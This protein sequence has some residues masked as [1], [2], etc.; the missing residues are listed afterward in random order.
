MKKNITLNLIIRTLAVGAGCLIFWSWYQGRGPDQHLQMPHKEE[1]VTEDVRAD[2][3][4]I[5]NSTNKVEPKVRHVVS[6]PAGAVKVPKLPSDAPDAVK[7]FRNWAEVYF[8]AEPAA[9]ASL[10]KKGQELAG[11]HRAAIKP[12]ISSDPKLALE[13]AVPMV[14]RQD[15]PDEIEQRLERRVN[16]RGDLM[17]LATVPTDGGTAV[18]SVRHVFQPESAQVG[19]SLDAYVYGDR[20]RMRSLTNTRV[21]GIEVDNKLAVLDSPIRQ[22][23]VGERPDPAK[24]T[25]ETCPISGITTPI[26][27]NS[28]AAPAPVQANVTVVEDSKRIYVLC[29]GGHT[30]RFA[31]QLNQQET[32]EHR[33]SGL[34][35]AEGGTGGGSTPFDVPPGWTNGTKKLLY[36]RV[37]FPDNLR[38]VQSEVSVYNNLKQATDF[39][40]SNSFGRYYLTPTVAPLVVLPY[41]RSWYLASRNSGGQPNGEDPLREHAL[42]IARRMGYDADSYDLDVVEYDSNGPGSFGGQ[43]FVGARGVWLKTS[44]VGTLIHELGHN[45]GLWH[46]N[47]WETNPPNRI[48]PGNND[49]YG[50]KF[51][52]MGAS[53][54]LG[55]FV[56]VHKTIL[57]WLTPDS[58]HRAS[59]SGTYRVYQVD[60]GRAD[61][62]KRYALATNMDSERNYWF[63][64]RQRFPDIASLN[65]G[66]LVTWNAWGSGVSNRADEAFSSH[67]GSHLLDM[68]PGSGD[69]ADTRDDAGLM[70]GQTFSDADAGVHV[71]PIFKSKTVPPYVDV[72]VNR[73]VFPTNRNPTL[74]IT[75][76]TLNVPVNGT[77]LLTAVA[78]DLDSDTISYSWNFGDKT[79]STDNGRTQIKKWT[80]LGKYQ[81]LCTASDMKGGRTT[82]SMLIIVGAEQG[83]DFNYTV[84]GR[85]L[86]NSLPTPKPVEGVYI[87]SRP[88]TNGSA[89][90]GSGAFRSTYTDSDG[91]Y[92]LTELISF[93]N[94]TQATIIASKW[95][96]TYSINTTNTFTLNNDKENVDWTQIGLVTNVVVSVTD[97]TASEDNAS[98]RGTI[99]LTR[100]NSSGILNVQM[101]VNSQGTA[102]R[103]LAFDYTL[104]NETNLATYLPAQVTNANNRE[105]LKG[106]LGV[107]FASGVSTVNIRVSAL[108]DGFV[109]GTEYAVIDFPDTAYAYPGSTQP[110]TVPYHVT[111]TRKAVIAITD[112][113]GT[114]PVVSLTAD[115]Q[116]M[117]EGTTATRDSA[118]LR[119]HREGSILNP[120]TVTL[121]YG[122]PTPPTR[123]ATRV[124]DY[125]RRTLDPLTLNPLTVEIPVGKSEVMVDFDP[126][127]DL[128]AEGLEVAT[129]SLAANAGYN[130]ST[131]LNSVDLY[132]AD[133]DQPV[134]QVK[135]TVASTGEGSPSPGRL[136]VSRTAVDIRDDLVVNF[137]LGGSALSGSD[138]KRISGIAVIPAN[139]LTADIM[140]ESFQDTIDEENQ[141]V[142]LKI[143]ADPNYAIGVDSTATVTIIDNDLSQFSIQSLSSTVTEPAANPVS[144]NLFRVFRPA[145]LAVVAPGAPP[146]PPGVPIVVKYKVSPFPMSTATAS[147]LVPIATN[148]YQALYNPNAQP[149]ASTTG[150]LLFYSTDTFKDISVKLNSDSEFEDAEK[151]TIELLPGSGY[152]LGSET[153]STTVILDDDQPAIDVSYADNVGAS[154]QNFTEASTGLRFYFSRTG[155]TSASRVVD[156][157]FG[158]TAL[159]GND[160]NTGS[161]SSTQIVI[162]AGQSGA[163]LDVFLVN[164]NIA[165][166]TESISVNI[167]TPPNAGAYGSRFP[168]STIY[169][170]DN[171]AYTGAPAPELNFSA[172]TSNANERVAG[173]TPGVFVASQHTIT[174][175]LN[176]A[177][178]G[179]VRV[180]YR[181]VGGSATGRGVDYTFITPDLDLSPIVFQPGETSKTFSFTT[182]AD[183]LP[184]GDETIVFELLNPF[185]A[186]LGAVKRH[187][188]TL[189]DA[190]I[191]EVL[192][193]VVANRPNG[194][195][196][197]RGR[198][199][200][201]NGITSAWFEWGKTPTALTNRVDVSGSMTGSVFINIAQTIPVDF[202]G[203]YYYRAVAS[204][205]Y[206]PSSGIVRTIRTL[207]KPTVVTT[208][209][210]GHTATS[211]TVAGTINSNR[212]TVNYYFKWGPTD[213]F[214]QETDKLTIASG[215]NPAVV[216]ALIG[217]LTEGAPVFYQLVAESVSIPGEVFGETM[218]STA[219]PYKA[220]GDLIVNIQANQPS[221]GTPS[222]L[223]LGKPAGVFTGTAATSVNINVHDT[224]IPG[225]FFDGKTTAYELSIPTPLAPTAPWTDVIAVDS[226]TIEVWAFNPG[227]GSP[228]TLLNMGKDGAETQVAINHSNLTQTETALSHGTKNADFTAKTLPALGRWN[229][230]TYVYEGPKKTA[231]LYI[232]GV[233][234]TTVSALTLATT[235]DPITV[236][237]ARNATGVLEKYMQ[238]YINS[239]RIHGGIL[240]LPDIVTNFNLGPAGNAPAAPVVRSSGISALTA[241]SVTLNGLVATSGSASTAWIEWGTSTTYD[242]AS[243][244]IPVAVSPVPVPMTLSLANLVP[245]VEY[246]YR[247]VAS[248][249][250][251]VK[252]GKDISFI[253]AVMPASGKLW[254]DLRAG[255]FIDGAPWKNTAA[256]GDFDLIGTPTVT[257]NVLDTG[258]PGVEFDGSTDALESSVLANSDFSYGD[259]QTLEVWVLNPT[260]NN[261]AETIV[262]QG[263]VTTP[264]SRL[265]LSYGSTSGADDSTSTNSWTTPPVA[266]QWT[267]LAVVV[268]AGT[269]TLYA[270]GVQVGPTTSHPTGVNQWDDQV[271]LGATRDAAG[272]PVFGADAFS[273]YINSVKIHGGAMLASK[274]KASFDAGPTRDT[275]APILVPAVVTSAPSLTSDVHATL[276]G[277]VQAGG[278]PTTYWFE[279]GTSPSALVNKTPPTVLTNLYSL[280]TVSGPIGGLTPSVAIHY[281]LV[282]QNTVKFAQV[283]PSADLKVEGSTLTFTPSIALAGLG[284]AQTNAATLITL[285][286]ATL[287]GLATPSTAAATAWFEY[288]PTSSMTL[289]SPSVAIP[290]NAA[291]NTAPKAMTFAASGLLPHTLYSFRLVV[292]NA[293]GV[294]VGSTLTFSSFNSVPVVTAVPLK[295]ME[296]VSTPIPLKGTDADKESILFVVGVPTKGTIT[297]NSPNFIYTSNANQSG[298]D[299]F[300]YTATDGA[301]TSAPA[302][303]TVT[304]TSVND[305][306]IAINATHSGPE[307]SPITASVGASDE[308]SDPITAYFVSQEPAS[309]S[310]S[311][312]AGTGA[313]TYTP[314]VGFYGAD[315]FEFRVVAGGQTSAPGV[316]TLNVTVPSPTAL[317]TSVFTAKNVNLESK[318]LAKGPVSLTNGYAKATDPNGAQGVVTAFN[319][320]NGNF[321]FQPAL[322]YVGNASFTFTVTDG[323][324]TSAPTIVTIVVGGPEADS[325]EFS[326]VEDDQVAGTLTATDPNAI[327]L[328]YSQVT[329]A[330][331]KNGTVVVNPNGT[332]T[333]NPKAGFVGVDRFDFQATN[334]TLVSNPG[335]VTITITKRPPNW[336]WTQGTNTAKA[337]GVYGTAGAADAAN[338][339]GARSDAVSWAE[340]NG[341]LWVFGGSGFSE[342]KVAGLLND[343]W[344]RDPITREWT[345][346]SGSKGVNA[347]GI[348]GAQDLAAATN[349]PGARSGAASWLGHDGKLWMFGGN[350]F[351]AAGAKAG[352]LNDLWVFDPATSWWTWVKGS[353]NANLN[354]TYGVK[355]AS[356]S[357]NTPGARQGA[358]TWVDAEDVLWLFG[359]IGQPGTG[360]VSGSLADLWKYNPAS[361]QWTWVS[362]PGTLNINGVYGQLGEV[363]STTIPGSRSYASGWQDKDG[364][365]YLFGGNGLGA[366]GKTTGFLNDVWAY[367]PESNRWAWIKGN[368]V[369]GPASVSGLLG[370]GDP[371]NNP[372]GRAGAMTWTA[373]TEEAWVFAG[374]SKSGHMNDVWRFDMATKVWTL[375]KGSATANAG[376]VYGIKGTGA[377]SN[378]PG[379]RRG[380]IAFADV[381][382]DLWLLGGANGAA[383][384]NDLWKLDRLDS[385]HVKTLAATGETNIS[386]TLNAEFLSA[387]MN[388][389]SGFRYWP[390]GNLSQAQTTSFYQHA[391]NSS[392]MVVDESVTGLT[393]GT[394]Y[395]FQTVAKVNGMT[396]YGQTLLF[397]TTGP[398][399]GVQVNFTTVADPSTSEGDG[400]YFVEIHLSAPAPSLVT[401]PLVVS[402]P[403]PL[404]FSG[405]A[406]LNLDYKTLN[407]V[408]SFP[409]GQTSS[410]IRIPLINDF[411]NEPDELF[412]VTAS[413]PS[414]PAVLGSNDVFVLTIQDDDF[415]PF[416]ITPPTS[417]FALSGEEV[418]LSVV[419]DGSRLTYQWKRNNVVIPKAT[420]S[421]Y[422]FV[423]ALAS[424][425]IYTCVISNEL[426]FTETRADVFV[427]ETKAKST[428]ITSGSASFS[429]KAASAAGASLVYRW[430]DAL[431]TNPNGL[432]VGNGVSGT[433]SDT[434]L[435]PNVVPVNSLR[436]ICR[437]SK[438]GFPSFFRDSAVHILS[439]PD[440]API[441]TSGSL[442]DG[443]VNTFY[444]F[445]IA[446]DP[447]LRKQASK[448][449]AAGLPQGLTINS[450]TGLISGK[451]T[452]ATPAPATVTIKASSSTLNSISITRTLVI[453]ALPAG[454][455]GTFVALLERAPATNYMGG[456]VDLAITP[457]GAYTLKL[458]MNGLTGSSSGSLTPVFTP[459]NTFVGVTGSAIIKR[460]V[461]QSNLTLQF[462]VSATGVLDCVLTDPDATPSTIANET[463][464]VRQTYAATPTGSNAPNIGDY[465]LLLELQQAQQGDLEIPQ[466]NG[467]ATMKLAADGKITGAGRTADG[468]AFTLATILGP[469]ADRKIPVYA[470][471]TPVIGSLI[472]TT[473][474]DTDG[475]LSGEMTWNKGPAPAT[476]KAA[477]YPTGF[478]TISLGVIGGRYEVAPGTVVGGLVSG[479]NNARLS[480]SEGGL[481]QS[482]LDTLVF[483]IT[484]PSPTKTA[485][486]IAIPPP[487]TNKLSFSLPASPAGSFNGKVTLPNPVT[488]LTR[489]LTFQGVIVKAGAST[490]KSAGYML[491]PQLPQPGQ[492]LTTSPIYSGQIV[493]EPNP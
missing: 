118:R 344:K 424:A 277:T 318:V 224:G 263:R 167:A 421:T 18:R 293:N 73:G 189:K 131:Q 476:T 121:N 299:T 139:E 449:E 95:P 48:G 185:G 411:N 230:F 466:G 140:I 64:F 33:K 489:N 93:N 161:A 471:F 423:A 357:T 474:V 257:A 330:N 124:D 285:G 258:Y 36:L 4:A 373:G 215:T 201:N 157:I 431:D 41:P 415:A 278:S 342:G 485:Q 150:E 209:D 379:A 351:D 154:L 461:G 395:A 486:V 56:A 372:S 223:N 177:Q 191:P 328:T 443:V 246:H 173:T 279:W 346:I 307:G 390:I 92:N 250:F 350:G 235:A 27:R 376:G 228:D 401:V 312:N 200:P 240:S 204:N 262:N 265:R 488:T 402:V 163:Y 98:D 225:V 456:R 414:G 369:V 29:S 152:Q 370:V 81:V 187:T 462:T 61:A 381:S 63:E 441:I 180:N 348:Y 45:L 472:G 176:V 242:N 23:E 104:A 155:S 13:L 416:V 22:L 388:Y 481:L 317:A 212:G 313:F 123:V 340:A 375:L 417:T 473:T 47:R 387:E 403:G 174:V 366:T 114:A 216:T 275:G 145:A 127:D 386:V 57:G 354:G 460:K 435:I 349:Q 303:V 333:Y 382:G 433:Q 434:L 16:D 305:A 198:V 253:P 254:V 28:Q 341:T 410:L 397:T 194:T 432:I 282:A 463:D 14:V 195:A 260:V 359:G 455:Q 452:V 298:V 77:T 103:G 37:A 427:L 252:E 353:L 475:Y 15:L 378:T 311:L 211:V 102:T 227:Y 448:F 39:F 218:Y 197:L 111:G 445:Q 184:E 160:Y 169:I 199:L 19:Q 268:S 82:R 220:A 75:S 467:Y 419:A 71:T 84:S 409:P 323:T 464:S 301:S 454:I 343:L 85:I 413:A 26:E 458:L 425:G 202:P 325:L 20:A 206:G 276:A 393:E 142:I 196:D 273:G 146:P 290:A 347:K 487:N 179:P 480:F 383:N 450:I 430:R 65:D 321:T 219:I 226:R 337:L 280:N 446:V 94:T 135:A 295:V 12:V 309:G 6:Q 465:T 407:T 125:D 399:A 437:V 391:P 110:R 25:V 284:K 35:L 153:Q 30:D 143:A 365:L 107:S 126:F 331:A 329:T 69:F 164:D 237:A 358:T 113:D 101:L 447:D 210:A 91:Y 214:G 319:A 264:A 392:S 105:E 78:S 55:D 181:L 229:L 182:T 136:Q 53:N 134:V 241:N 21:S 203:T 436:Y 175:S 8:A 188:V 469:T 422:K 137:S 130:I 72:V 40:M 289:K 306:P 451:P 165:E 490:W 59:A 108:P 234:N 116:N 380:A 442:P 138:Y 122:G 363:S 70:I 322:N 327:A 324:V 283:P 112:G 86:D 406:E 412:T 141:T 345:W 320:N 162:G 87:S 54:A 239:V 420:A 67:Y 247:A 261:Q 355:G 362:G 3:L 170:D 287:N 168:S 172:A 24:P 408:V 117:V 231:T 238:G 149:P 9:R 352:N 178:P 374:Q 272:Q 97:A 271:L 429:V 49:E 148:D 371:L 38:D 11:L 335:T 34:R 308:E 159:Q 17:V 208:T 478:P 158:G 2:F 356:V 244:P 310:V 438:A 171:D 147:T 80:K 304:I 255:E 119:L 42:E 58:V 453:Q 156:F 281:R 62:D 44:A 426:D 396:N 66:L 207:A 205:E 251:G 74:S 186:N 76:D 115:D 269:R 326:G 256:L 468:N 493:L 243:A 286:K 405:I 336:V 297:G 364:V 400:D 259:D 394:T 477:F 444:S 52:V 245:G 50:N 300:T 222:W 88:L 31:D 106:A 491:I 90:S 213:A 183:A 99:T 296:N 360:A 492:T 129:V 5:G 133:N 151:L 389:E 221:A 109:E 479:L 132:L 459:P 377:A 428:L 10:V 43:G 292:Q 192:T 96:Q 193:D 439:V 288:G 470:A 68:T 314:D 236:G 89:Q 339:P 418:S 270:N 32:D 266:G 291:P 332:F 368:I 484:N 483:S 334:G 190:A 267:H 1:S 361:N 248:N 457:A 232:N 315:R 79:F 7:D 338:T 274:I 385:V 100:S 217:G 294:V 60:Q 316:I 249:A 404:D 440:A 144:Q 83:L 384:F 46:A 128:I 302:T 233:K 367:Y 166:G 398:A 482:E 120:L 51:D